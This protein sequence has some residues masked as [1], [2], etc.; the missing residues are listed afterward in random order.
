MNNF[1]DLKSFDSGKDHL[2]KQ[3]VLKTGLSKQKITNLYES[4]ELNSDGSLKSINESFIDYLT[5]K[6]FDFEGF[7]KT[8]KNFSKKIADPIIDDKSREKLSNELIKT[9]EKYTG[10][11]VDIPTLLEIVC[12]VL[13]LKDK[14]KFADI[15]NQT[16]FGSSMIRLFESHEI[17]SFEKLN[18]SANNSIDDNKQIARE[19]VRLYESL[20]DILSKN[21]KRFGFNYH[22][23]NTYNAIL[24]YLKNEIEEIK[25][26]DAIFTMNTQYHID[27]IKDFV[28]SRENNPMYRSYDVLKT[29]VPDMQTFV[30]DLAILIN[31]YIVANKQAMKF[32][33]KKTVLD[34]E[35]ILR[36]LISEMPSS[37]KASRI[38]RTDVITDG[39]AKGYRD[40]ILKNLSLDSREIDFSHY[41]VDMNIALN[42]LHSI[43]ACTP[44][45]NLKMRQLLNKY[46]TK[47]L[48]LLVKSEKIVIELRNPSKQIN[49]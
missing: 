14:H 38:V 45:F 25:A 4:F 3:M 47:A 29:L 8:I 20:R 35:D 46:V 18:M 48:E 23:D 36:A 21:N 6:K 19:N 7:K 49:F 34:Y 40:D 28:S 22:L 11:D 24:D 41:T 17:E 31:S 43:K 42:M 30:F 9:I 44:D 32:V 12:F 10:I 2:I 1:S 37:I 16:E 26:N 13:M 39:D 5:P 15:K 33:A 27:I